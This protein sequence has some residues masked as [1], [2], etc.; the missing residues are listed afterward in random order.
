[1]AADVHAFLRELGA[2]AADIE[3]ATAEGWLPLLALDRMLMPDVARYD[4][5]GVAAAAGTTPEVAAR[6]WRALGFPDV[7]DGVAVFA[8][9]DARALR[10]A[11]ERLQGTATLSDLEHQ[12]RVVSASL[13][14]LAAF[15]ADLVA[16]SLDALRATGADEES[17]AMALVERAD[18]QSV[19]ELSDYAHRI[20]FRAAVWRR[21]AR[22][23]VGPT[24]ELAVGF[25][26]IAGYTELTEGLDEHELSGLLAAFELLAYDTAAQHNVRIVKTIGDEVMFVGPPREMV[27]AAI[28]LT[29]RVAADPVVPQVRVGLAYGSV[30]GRD[31]DYYGPVVNL[32]SRIT[33]R[34]RRG[35]VL[36]SALLHRILRED[37]AFTWRML[38]PARLR[39]IGEVE[40]FVVRRAT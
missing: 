35:S 29:E 9:R 22:A 6:I 7:P 28:T 20:L 39:G 14:R 23:S 24:V 18:W 16:E 2:S 37:P 19:S 3:R 10:F 33:G 4:A 1:M 40:V 36:T 11:V 12:V 34:A 38:R 26:D 32:A 17:V 30:L 21:L 8:D 31:G 13:A 5:A 25:A 27:V 15:E